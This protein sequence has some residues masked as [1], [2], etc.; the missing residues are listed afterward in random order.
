MGEKKEGKKYCDNLS[1][2]IQDFM[3]IIEIGT[4]RSVA[5]Y[6]LLFTLLQEEAKVIR[7][8]KKAISWD[9]KL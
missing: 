1:S 3:K 6:S 5:I 8:E 4:K 2:F 9:V 7:V